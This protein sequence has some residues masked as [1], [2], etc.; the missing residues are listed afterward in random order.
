MGPRPYGR[1]K[2]S[3]RL[4]QIVSIRLL[5]WGLDLTVEESLRESAV[6]HKSF[7][8]LQWGLDLTV[9][10]SALA[11]NSDVVV[12]QLQWGLDLTVEERVL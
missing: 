5:Q 1:G 7:V 2:L 11:A 4:G 6:C 3:R 12:D 8:W 10:E 9:E